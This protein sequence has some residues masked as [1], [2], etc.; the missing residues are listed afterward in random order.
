MPE[1]MDPQIEKKGLAQF[2]SNSL[3]IASQSELEELLAQPEARRLVQSTPYQDLFMVVKSI[4]LADSLE[5]LPLTRREQ[6]CGFVDLDCWVKD[7]V[8]MAHFTEWMA[9]FIQCGPEET[10]R[11]CRGLDPN[12]LALFLKKNIAVHLIDP[13][14]PKPDLPLIY[15]PDNRYGVEIIGE[16]E[17]ATIAR[18]LLD[19]LFR[20]DPSLGYDLLDRVLNGN[21]AFLEEEA[22][23]NKRDRLEEL[24]FV[25][26]Y[27]ALEI[28][29]DAQ[30]KPAPAK[31]KSG[32]DEPAVKTSKMLPALLVTALQPGDFLRAGLVKIHEEAD[33]ERISQ[34]L[35][36]LSNRIL[37]VRSATPG[38]LEKILPAL[39]EVRDTLN[40]ALEYLTETE[41]ERSA[42]VLLEN[43]IKLLFKTGFNLTVQLRDRADAILGQGTLRLPSS[44]EL[45]LEWPEQEFFS[46]LRR[47][48]PLFYEG[49]ENAKKSGYRNFHSFADI[50]IS[51]Q[52]LERIERLGTAFMKLFQ[53]SASKLSGAI[54]G[55]INLLAEELRFGAIF[56][57]ALLNW[58]LKKDFQAIPL[59]R[60]AQQ[61][62][63]EQAQQF[64]S[65]REDLAEWLNRA[66]SE[67]IKQC[68]LGAEEEKVLLGYAAKWV[69]KATDD[70]VP[71]LKSSRMDG[72]FVKNVMLEREEPK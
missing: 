20:F 28:Y 60:I 47:V 55:K 22:Y 30:V 66:A 14:E 29:G 18:L 3:Y 49:I 71:H 42:Q 41:K 52:C 8:Q 19:G 62:L 50:Q 35:A 16:P 32:G 21:E 4:G 51:R 72:R 48:Q 69:R 39:G 67:Y 56:N 59:D 11:T 34:S 65:G 10:V 36:S 57:T 24:G 53:P 1:E 15:T 12:L 63:L 31:P 37:S 26:Y 25:D 64:G 33:V 43:D 13:E 38:D 58:I 2:V 9:A 46:G 6:R 7:S 17:P 68:G 45:L 61:A 40:L 70:I 27:E 23:Q 44:G 54:L 5:L